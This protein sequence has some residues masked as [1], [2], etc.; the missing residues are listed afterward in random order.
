MQLV[1]IIIIIIIISKSFI[2]F[3]CSLDSNAFLPFLA[4]QIER[5]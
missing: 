2:Y 1:V 4:S 3:Q 5:G